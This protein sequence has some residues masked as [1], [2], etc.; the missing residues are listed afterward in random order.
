MN[1]LFAFFLMILVL[2]A[3]SSD[4]KKQKEIAAIPVNVDVIR[5]D[6]VFANSTPDDLPRLKEEFPYLFPEQF[7]DSVWLERMQDTLQIELE[8]EVLK[9]YDNFSKQEEDI[10]KLFQHL[11]YYFPEF[12]E[13]T[14]VTVISEVDY[15]NKVIATDRMLLVGLDNF[16]GSEHH[17]Y[18]GIHTYIS[19]NLTPEQLVPQIAEAYA[20]QLV[21]PSNTRTL[22]SG[23]VYHG[24]ILYLKELLLSD[25]KAHTVMGYTQ[26]EL[27]WA[28]DNEA[29]IWRYFIE[30]ELLF[31]TDARLPGRF[32]IPAPFSKFYLELDN[33][34][35]GRL[36]QYIGW[37]IV[38]AYMKNNETTLQQLL[39]TPADEIY[40]NSKFKPRK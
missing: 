23:M 5:F 19:K 36:G 1:R 25:E 16:L 32:L 34:S 40:K 9:V 6:K 27:Q 35:P 12:T 29:E 8:T 38:K 37:Q 28:E 15:R 4:R 39:T 24:K 13:P 33:E 14:I 2:G 17:F 18:S 21:R 10:E 7:P 11:K 20:T 31:S 22:L 3:C 30:R 26:E